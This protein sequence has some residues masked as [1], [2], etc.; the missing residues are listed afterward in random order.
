MNAR[1]TKRPARKQ[2]P[3]LPGDDWPSDIAVSAERMSAEDLFGVQ[4]RMAGLPPV[5]RG[6]MFAKE[7]TGRQWKFDYAFLDFKLAIEIEG[8]CVM[9]RCAKCYP[10]QFI[11]TGRHATPGGFKEDCV[12]Y[13]TASRLGWRLLRFEQRLVAPRHAINETITTL[14]A[15]GWLA[16]E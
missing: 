5:V 16:H 6:L 7:E 9:R 3:L 1:R 13:N 14:A 4:C 15:F 10:K 11:V 12:K 2:L 8:L